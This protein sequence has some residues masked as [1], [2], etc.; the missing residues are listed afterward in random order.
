MANDPLAT[1]HAT[2]GLRSANEVRE[3]DG[4]LASLP[5]DLSAA[6]IGDLYRV[7][8]DQTEHHEVMFGL[9]HFVEHVDPESVVFLQVL[10]EMGANAS[11]WVQTLMMR[12]L[13]ND[14]C[15]GPFGK[16]VAGAPDVARAA[17]IKILREIVNK[18]KPVA[19]RARL[20]LEE[21]DAS[22]S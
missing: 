9:L 16:L 6:Q 20:V 12:I 19:E 4:A 2:R 7:F 18:G 13:N 11:E 22:Q 3:F 1:L 14:S 8:D 10:P 17:A 5:E 21:L 15:R